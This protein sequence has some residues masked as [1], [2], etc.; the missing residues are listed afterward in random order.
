MFS[1]QLKTRRDALLGSDTAHTM[2]S[3]TER[4]AHESMHM[5]ARGTQPQ[6]R[7]TVY[8]QMRTNKQADDFE[9]TCEDACDGTAKKS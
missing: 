5:R 8:T 7:Y 9:D 1:Q 6:H 4:D 2:A 3:R